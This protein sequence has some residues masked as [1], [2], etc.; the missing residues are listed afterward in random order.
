MGGLLG[1]LNIMEIILE[2]LASLSYVF[3]IIIIIA[4]IPAI[5]GG[6]KRS[7]LKTIFRIL[8]YGGVFLGVYLNIDTI[9]AYVG[10]NFLVLIGRQISYTYDETVYTFTSLNEFFTAI[11]ELGESDASVLEGV[12]FT[13]LKNVTWLI[14][15]P[16]ITFV[17]YIVTTVLWTIVLIFFPRGLRKKIKA[18]KLQ[19]INVPLSIVMTLTISLLTIS[20]YVNLSQGLSNII[21][22]PESPV[23]FLSAN[24]GRILAW[25]TPEKSFILNFLQGFGITDMFVFFDT[26][27]VG[28]NNYAFA[29][30]LERIINVVGEIT[31]AS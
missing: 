15:V 17:S 31:P 19:I 6:A 1:S 7:L 14:A 8:V 24:Y 28:S 10:D 3:D 30:E 20:P 21:I 12:V 23:A 22:D 11:L 16:V 4:L 18:F 27:S 5:I 26:F 2:G 29:G 25:F 9:S 13:L